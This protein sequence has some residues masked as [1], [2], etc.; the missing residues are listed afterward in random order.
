MRKN[1]KAVC[2]A[3]TN[4]KARNER[5]TISTDGTTI[6]SYRMPIAT[7]IANTWYVV[8]TEMSPTVTTSSHINSTAYFFETSHGKVERVDKLP[9]RE[10]VAEDLIEDGM[11]PAEAFTVCGCTRPEVR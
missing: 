1:V 7:R 5:G 4:G 10:A 8:R 11:E 9:E 6:F 3:A 2:I